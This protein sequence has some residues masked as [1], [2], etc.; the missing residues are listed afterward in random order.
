MRSNI[1]TAGGLLLFLAIVMTTWR[2][3]DLRAKNNRITEKGIVTEMYETD[4]KDLVL[5]L[6]G[7]AESYYI[8]AS[9]GG[10]TL[11]ELKEKVLY[12]PVVIQYPDRWTPLKKDDAKHFITSLSHE[13]EIIYLDNH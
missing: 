11:A 8:D 13:G 6:K 2:P 5:K 7:Q 10:L 1:I 12:K 3:A 9:M 4:F